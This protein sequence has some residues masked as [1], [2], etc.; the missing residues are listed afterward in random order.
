MGVLDGQVALITGASRGIGK[1]IALAFA[2]AGASLTIAA[3]NVELLEQAATELRTYGPPVLAVPTDVSEEA[4]VQRL[5]ERALSAHG[6][7]DVLVNNAGVGRHAPIVDSD[8]N[9]W[10]AT[11]ATN[12]RGPFLC[13]RAALR[14]MIPRKRGRI[15][16]I[17]SISSQRVRP[18]TA[19]YSASK[20]GLW[21]LTQVTAL[22]GRPH[23]ISCSC[24]NPG[25]VRVERRVERSSELDREPMMVPA[26]L[27]Q[28]AVLM[29][30]LPPHVNLLEATVLPVGQ[31]FVGRG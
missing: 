10:D 24:L 31:L 8:M 16:N 3:R 21:G 18:H 28:I 25:N 22:E 26:E 12:L 30:A 20:F 11:I 2:Q 4:Q 29:A 19:S 9:D 23:G 14:A 17:A 27:A 7:L 6:R 15:I 5:F 13:T 1:G